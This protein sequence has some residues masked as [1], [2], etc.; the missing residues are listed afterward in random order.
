MT[1]FRH[2]CGENCGDNCYLK[3]RWDPNCLGK[4][5]EDERGVWPFPYDGGEC[6]ATDIDA[7]LERKGRV[8]IVENKQGDEKK[9]HEHVQSWIEDKRRR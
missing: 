9:G 6:S 3:V 1:V 8:L 7:V 4:A 2:D 5:Y